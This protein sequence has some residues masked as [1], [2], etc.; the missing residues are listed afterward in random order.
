V[1]KRDLGKRDT[2]GAAAPALDSSG[3]NPYG[4]GFWVSR[5]DPQ[6][7]PRVPF[8]IYRIALRGPSG[9]QMQ[10]YVDTSFATGTLLGSLNQF[11]AG[12][13]EEIPVDS[14]S[15]IILFWNAATAPAPFASL[16]FRTQG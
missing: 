6:V 13:G 7:L 16:Y 14:G 8:E 9:I 5:F 15:S 11:T 2:V 4:S 10:L 12:A 1:A 3:L